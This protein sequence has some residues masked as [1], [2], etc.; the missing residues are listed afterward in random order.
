MR[1]M[2]GNSES[3]FQPENLGTSR[4]SER[5]PRTRHMEKGR[6]R[7]QAG[8]PHLVAGRW[9]NDPCGYRS[10]R[11]A[12]VGG[13]VNWPTP[14]RPG[15]LARSLCSAGAKPE[16]YGDESSTPPA[17]K[18]RSDDSR[19]TNTA[20]A[21]LPY[22]V[23]HTSLQVRFWRRRLRRPAAPKATRRGGYDPLNSRSAGLAF[24]GLVLRPPG[25]QEQTLH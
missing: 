13:L 11:H 1:L 8:T 20:S 16:R 9:K 25:L 23:N 15:K 4:E 22:R 3:S 2:A 21:P 18:F 6:T 17:S 5:P 12:K 14:N 10:K 24:L 19:R 7:G